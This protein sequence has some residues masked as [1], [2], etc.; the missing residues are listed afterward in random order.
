MQAEH[1]YTA[2]HAAAQ[3]YMLFFFKLNLL[4]IFLHTENKNY[5]F[6][7]KIPLHKIYAGTNFCFL[8][9]LVLFNLASKS[10]TSNRFWSK[11]NK[12]IVKIRHDINFMAWKL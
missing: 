3:V 11:S 8:Q 12:F 7:V 1:G 5:A 2:L 4:K 6:K 10:E 9:M